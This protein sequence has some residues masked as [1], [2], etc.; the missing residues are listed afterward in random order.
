M[1]RGEHIQLRQYATAID[2]WTRRYD[3]ADIA[4]HIGVCEATV[5][6]WVHNFREQARGAVA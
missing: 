2:M 4:N 6:R 5:E 3:T 1:P